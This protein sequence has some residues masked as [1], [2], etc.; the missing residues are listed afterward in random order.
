MQEI[1]KIY[2]EYVLK[3]KDILEENEKLKFESE[4]TRKTTQEITD[5]NKRIER[6]EKNINEKIGIEN[7]LKAEILD[8][9]KRKNKLQLLYNESKISVNSRLISLNYIYIYG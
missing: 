2:T 3:S 7:I 1:K 9:E 4:L 8:L 5:I 6:L